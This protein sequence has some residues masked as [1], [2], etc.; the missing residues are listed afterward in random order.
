MAY[1]LLR[2]AQDAQLRER[3][4]ALPW[5]NIDTPFWIE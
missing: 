2:L 5:D 1:K 4:W 3:S